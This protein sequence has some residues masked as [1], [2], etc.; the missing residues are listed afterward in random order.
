MLTEQVVNKLEI[1]K[2]PRDC[3]SIGSKFRLLNQ[4]Y[5]F[6]GRMQGRLPLAP[7][8]MGGENVT[9]CCAGASVPV[10]GPVVSLFGWKG[11]DTPAAQR[12]EGTAWWT[13]SKAR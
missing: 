8:A 11:K 5:L 6:T 1:A 7:A 2:R 3:N 9:L 4:F 13:R 12:Q 10:R